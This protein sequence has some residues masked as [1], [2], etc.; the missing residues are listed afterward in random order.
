MPE[1][2]QDP[3]TKEWVVI[4]TERAKRPDQLKLT[5]GTVRDA[6][7][8]VDNCP[9][10]PGNERLTPSELFSLPSPEGARGSTWRVRVVPN[11]FA[12][13]QPEEMRHRPTSGSFFN[14]KDAFG[15]H[16]VIIQTPFHDRI[17]PLMDDSEIFDVLQTYCH[18]YEELRKDRRI[19]LVLL[20]S[21]HG[22]RAGSS[23]Q[24][25]HSQLV[26]SPIIPLH[27]RKKYDVA[28]RHYDD[29]GRCLYC[30]VVQEEKA[31]ADRVVAETDLLLVFHPFASRVPF[32]TWIVPKDHNPCLARSSKQELAEL[33]SV[34]RRSL[35]GLHDALGNPHLNIIAHTAP[36]E[37]EEKPYFLWHVEIH[38][39]LTTVAGF[40]LGTGIY[41]NT[42]VPEETAP[43]M[44]SILA[45][46]PAVEEQK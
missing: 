14:R 38:P 35:R 41:I 13:F 8:H 2:R 43:F 37:D 9:F 33:A 21:N 18:L 12:A 1:L 6:A 34:L 22:I 40:E 19:K 46:G 29:T 17:L 28:I 3:T 27:I 15:H 25:P 26:A 39:R 16:L 10:C 7:T 30:D 4:A 20:F 31:A 32:E 36:V 11:K 44:R 24:H 5:D 45:A 42:A 23:L